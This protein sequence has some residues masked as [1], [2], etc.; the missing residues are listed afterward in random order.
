MEKQIKT[1]KDL[2]EF[3]EQC[4]DTDEIKAGSS[5]IGYGYIENIEYLGKTVYISV[6]YP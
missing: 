2:K 1:V 4:E 5:C 3:L 6:E